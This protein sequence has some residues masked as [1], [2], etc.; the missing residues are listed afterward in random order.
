MDRPS[1]CDQTLNHADHPQLF[2]CTLPGR[3]G[4]LKN[5]KRIV[6]R[7]PKKIGVLKSEAYIQWATIAGA[8]LRRTHTG[9][10]ISEPVNLSVTLYYQDHAGEQDCTNAIQGIEDLLAEV[11]VLENDKLIYSLNGTRKVY[12]LNE[13]ERARIELTPYLW[14]SPG[15]REQWLEFNARRL[16]RKASSQGKRPPSRLQFRR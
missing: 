6:R 11:G 4:I 12:D 3:P 14:E 1:S 9:P 16:K 2:I 5:S 8:L 15:Q 7:G 10:P 13:P